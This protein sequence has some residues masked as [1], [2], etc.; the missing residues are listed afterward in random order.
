[1][2]TELI[3]DNQDNVV[4]ELDQLLDN[5]EKYRTAIKNKDSQQL[6]RLLEEGSERKKS[7]DSR[8]TKNV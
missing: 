7:I 2:W 8:N 4:K 5:L 3:L 1:M 6:K